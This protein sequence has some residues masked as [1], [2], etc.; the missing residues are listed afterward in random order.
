LPDSVKPVLIVVDMQHYFCEPQSAFGRLLQAAGS[1]GNGKWYFEWLSTRVIPNI[2]RL[3]ERFR[4]EGFRVLFT[5]FGSRTADGSDLPPWA[6][7][8]N[9]RCLEMVGERCYLPLSAPSSRVIDALAPLPGEAVIEK[10]TSGPL[11]GTDIQA[12]LARMGAGRVVVV[13]VATDV[14]V[15]GMARELADTGLGVYVVADACATPVEASHD[16]A[17]RCLGAT[18]AT[19]TSTDQMLSS[20]AN[21][22]VESR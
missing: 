18:F 4:K 5:E 2:S 21:T 16:W 3:M 13:G 6:R 15:L 14:C 17:L 22:E 12:R 10:S 11:A 7:R 1:E 19:V 8:H 20:L 9:E